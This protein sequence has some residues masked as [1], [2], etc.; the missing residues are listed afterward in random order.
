MS[1]I[2]IA[3]ITPTLSRATLHRAIES[4]L[5]QLQPRDEWFVVGDGPQPAAR[6]IVN[7]FGNSCFRYREH[8]EPN[9]RFGNAQRNAAMREAH[10]DYFVFLDDDD[11]LLPGAL[12]A[13]RREG[14]HRVPLM[15]RMDYRP[16]SC[17]LWERQEIYEGNVAGAMFVVPNLTGYW[18][19]WPVA[20]RPEISD[21]S[22]IKETLALWPPDALRWCSDVIYLCYDHGQG[23]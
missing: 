5:C 6:E 2:T 16:R 12:D 22:F 15:F 10:A 17:I 3:L 19:G 13:I 23:R 21:L 1:D 9:S 20:D 7:S 14:I 4:A 18:T 11:V 8:V